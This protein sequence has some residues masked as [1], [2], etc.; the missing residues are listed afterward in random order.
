MSD[1]VQGLRQELD[2]LRDQIAKFESAL[3]DKPD[4]GIGEGDPAIAEW[5]MN[6]AMLEQSKDR[7]AELERALSQAKNGEY[8]ICQEC[9]EPIHPDRLEVLPGTTLCIRCA[10]ARAGQRIPG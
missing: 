2:R 6:L 1:K 10:R 5:E 8:G 7:V 3:E 9:G 4:Y